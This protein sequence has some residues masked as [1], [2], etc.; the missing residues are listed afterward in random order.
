M[1]KSFWLIIALL[2]VC[3]LALTCIGHWPTSAEADTRDSARGSE[4]Q[5]L[6]SL[7]GPQSL[8]GTMLLLRAR[9]SNIVV[10]YHFRGINS[11]QGSAPEAGNL[12]G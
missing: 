2:L 6:A 1:A 11:S 10:K 4:G 7:P 12:S 8:S 3:P 9:L 5:G